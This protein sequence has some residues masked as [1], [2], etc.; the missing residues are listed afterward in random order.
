MCE[1]TIKSHEE[2]KQV[3]KTG[4]NG[5][6]S[7]ASSS[8]SVASPSPVP[9]VRA[10]GTTMSLSG[11]MMLSGVVLVIACATAAYFGFT[12]RVTTVGV[13]LGE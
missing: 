2:L 4:A 10:E 6:A 7:S 11:F 5:N 3:S 8:S 13:D 9:V 12:G 1:D